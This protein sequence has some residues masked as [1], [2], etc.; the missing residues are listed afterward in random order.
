MH[1][2][3]EKN[4]VMFVVEK[5]SIQSGMPLFIIRKTLTSFLMQLRGSVVEEVF[6][7]HHSAKTVF[8][9]TVYSTVNLISRFVYEIIQKVTNCICEVMKQGLL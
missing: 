6:R 2:S 9:I 8:H 3:E 4:E 7:K 1:H 5:V